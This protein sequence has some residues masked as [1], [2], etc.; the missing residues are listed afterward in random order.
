MRG[1][2]ALSAIPKA[3]SSACYSPSSR[4][5]PSSIRSIYPITRAT[6]TP[7]PSRSL[8]SSHG[9]KLVAGS[10]HNRTYGGIRHHGHSASASSSTVGAVKPI[11]IPIPIPIPDIGP[12]NTYDIVIIGGANAGLAFACAL[13]AQPTIAASTRILLLEGSSLDK[14]RNWTGKGDWENRISSLTWENISWLESIGVWKHIEHGRSCPVEEMVIWANPSPSSFPTIHFPPLGHPMARMTE[15]MNLQRALLRRIEEVGKGIV[16]IK[17]GARVSE[18]RLGEGERWVGLKVGEEWLKGSLVV[19]ADGPNSPVRL[20]SGIEV[21]GHAYQTHAVVATLNHPPSPLYPNTTAFQRFLPTGPIAFLPLNEETS[22]MVWSTLPQHAKAL[23]S[24][25]SDALT[26]MINAGYQ[27]PESA[28]TKLTD[29]MVQHDQIGQPLSVDQINKIIS[30][31]LLSSSGDSIPAEQPILPPTITSVHMPSVASFPLRLSHA[32]E[33]L[34]KRTALVGDA[35]HTIHPLAGQGLNQG[36]AD[37]RVLAQTLENARKLGGD[38]GSK[39]SLA[40]Y[41][42]ERYP[43]NH[44]ILSTTDKL[45]YIFRARNPIVDWFRGTGLE[46]INEISPLKKILMGGAG[47]V[48]SS[49][50]SS[51]SASSPPSPARI[52]TSRNQPQILSNGLTEAQRREFGRSHPEDSLADTAGWQ[53]IAANSVEGWFTLKGVVGM[54]GGIAGGLLSEGMKRAAGALQ[55]K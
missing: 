13:L 47:A 42:R 9:T 49:T 30:A 22:T 15:N 51:S 40:D 45:H 5:S 27:L 54:A 16:D 11:P 12:E 3:S 18:M 19:G 21:Y 23:K 41:P 25:S 50:P 14:T 37:V 2:T 39:T 33:Y 44:L 36:L 35:A 32:E 26:S 17:E 31:S 4:S 55:K 29:Q 8:C 34:G 28:L 24:L 10:T 46:I 7:V 48:P 43:L 53:K 6:S 1:T 38:L 52:A 20:F